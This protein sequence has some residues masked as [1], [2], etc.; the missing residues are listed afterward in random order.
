MA[1][2]HNLAIGRIL[3]YHAHMSDTSRKNLDDAWAAIKAMDL[4]TAERLFSAAAEAAP[5]DPDA[6]NGLGAVHFERAELEDSLRCYQK[7]RELALKA[8]G[9]NFPAK[10]AWTDENKPALR[11]MLGIGLN[12]FRA[13]KLDEARETFEDILKRNPEDN[14]GVHFLLDDIKKKR[15][16]WKE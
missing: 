2:L 9:A 15:R 11:A 16:L 7:A 12:L 5:E 14:Q 3:R 1:G 10:M 8:H 4:A 6:W 13:G